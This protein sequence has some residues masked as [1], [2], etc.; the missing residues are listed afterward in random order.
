MLKCKLRYILVG[1]YFCTLSYT[2]RLITVINLPFLIL[3][4]LYMW[5]MMLYM[6]PIHIFY[7]YT[8][9]VNI[10]FILFTISIWRIT[11]EV[12][13]ND[14]LIVL[15]FNI[16]NFCLSTYWCNRGIVR[17]IISPITSVTFKSHLRRKSISEKFSE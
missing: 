11:R 12:I 15:Q 5:E 16:F 13:S 17:Q 2:L 9:M 7:K 4:Q 10:Y 6:I 1:V 8:G 14:I 3:I